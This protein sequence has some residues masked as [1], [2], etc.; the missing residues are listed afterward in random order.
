MKFLKKLTEI[1]VPSG[2]E[3][4]MK[5]FLMDYIEKNKSSWKVQP[6]II[7]GEDFQDNIILVFGEPR[8][9]IFAHMDSVGY[10]VGY[11]NNLIKIGGPSAKKGA[12]LVGEDS[13]GR[14]EGELVT[15][16]DEHQFLTYSLKFDRE[17]DRATTLTYKPDFREDDE[18][19]QCCYM[20]NRLGMW[21]ALEVAKTLE[22][23]AIVFSSWE[24]HG[25]GSVGY[26]G[27]F[28]YEG[29]D[30][31]QALIA[32]I[33]WVT[34]GVE[35]NK[36]VA[37]SMRDSGIPRRTYLNK[38]VSLAKESK[39]PFQLE[40]ESAGGS[41]GNAL[42]RS[43]YPF[44]WCFIGAPEDNVHTPDE[45]VHKNDIKAMVD[46]YNYLMARL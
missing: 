28:L 20:D 35:H 8:T 31:K 34:K 5:E 22:N 12:K 18:F 13:K 15:E 42:Q 26:L 37:I 14:I 2:S 17:V 21:V 25:G 4:V 40:V 19:V 46:M 29:Y 45:K 23:G 11:D 3:Y 30:V 6:E 24:E 9:A 44:D 1:E 41:D 36:G 7:E 39:I 16:E 33:T 32:D 43:P 38:I 10:T 27:K